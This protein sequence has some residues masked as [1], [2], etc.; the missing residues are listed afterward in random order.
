MGACSWSARRDQLCA[1]AVALYEAEMLPMAQTRSRRGGGL[2]ARRL[3]SVL[4][5]LHHLVDTNHSCGCSLRITVQCVPQ[6]EMG[7][8]RAR[9]EHDQ[10]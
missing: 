8:T 1:S 2:F 5:A 4:G 7:R 10:V 6:G 3:H 9:C